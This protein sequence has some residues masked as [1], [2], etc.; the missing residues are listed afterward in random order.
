MES[1]FNTS[2]RSVISLALPW[3]NAVVH[4]AKLIHTGSVYINHTLDIY[5][6]KPKSYVISCRPP[7]AEKSAEEQPLYLP[8]KNVNDLRV[9]IGIASG[10]YYLSTSQIT[11]FEAHTMRAAGVLNSTTIL[12]RFRSMP[13]SRNAGYSI[14]LD[15]A[16]VSQFT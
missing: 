4:I 11:D 10:S 13:V 9:Y 5:S 12:S 16:I 14:L 7:A 15:V 2:A 8:Q 1:P 3:G 6:P